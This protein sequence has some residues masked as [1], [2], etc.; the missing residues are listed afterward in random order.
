[1][2]WSVW[3]LDRGTTRCQEL[4]YEYLFFRNA[5]RRRPSLRYKNRSLANTYSFINKLSNFFVY[6][7]LKLK[8]LKIFNYASVF[9]LY[10]FYST[11]TPSFFLKK[12]KYRDFD[13][14]FDTFYLMARLVDSFSFFSDFN[15]L[16]PSL[17][18]SST[19]M[20]KPLVLRRSFFKKK[21]IPN[22]IRTKFNIKYLYIP[23]DQRFFTVLRWFAMLL[24]FSKKPLVQRFLEMTLDSS[25][26]DNSLLIKLRNYV[27]E[28]LAAEHD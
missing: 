1:M 19:P 4:A 6:K 16:L 27:Y 20:V 5:I 17:L 15:I 10:K 22:R 2:S 24:K 28:R 8:Y 12:F 25:L 14:S 3:C 7:G 13:I 23:A 9:F 18:E 26:E 11:N 21:K